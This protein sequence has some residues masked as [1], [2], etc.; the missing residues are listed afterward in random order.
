[1]TTT[2]IVVPRSPIA[3][4]PY[5]SA[6][7]VTKSDTTT[8]SPPTRALYVGGTGNLVVTMA[9]GSGPI[10]IAAA[11]VG[12]HELSVTQVLAATAATNIVGLY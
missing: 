10:T 5:A 6:F 1:M 11:A 12:Y 4:G 9:D 2:P 3:P 7:A 8:F